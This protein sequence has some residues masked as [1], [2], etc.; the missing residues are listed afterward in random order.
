[1][2][3]TWQLSSIRDNAILLSGFSPGKLIIKFQPAP[4]ALWVPSKLSKQ[5]PQ[6]NCVIQ[7][8]ISED[9]LC[10]SVTAS[11]SVSKYLKFHFCLLTSPGFLCS[12]FLVQ[13]N[14]RAIHNDTVISIVCCTFP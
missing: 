4:S 13:K 14:S 10:A 12:C 8:R 6:I 3:N 11:E 5:E 2:Y 9:F 1:M 7:D